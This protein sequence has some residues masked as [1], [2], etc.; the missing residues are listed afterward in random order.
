MCVSL[1]IPIRGLTLPSFKPVDFSLLQ[2][3]YLN[4]DNHGQK[5][6]TEEKEVV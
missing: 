6:F 3:M 2:E 4:N 5:K 1:Y